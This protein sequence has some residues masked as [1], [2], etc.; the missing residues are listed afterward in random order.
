MS[1]AGTR[2]S[3]PRGMQRSHAKVYDGRRLRDDIVVWE[4]TPETVA[5]NQAWILGQPDPVLQ[6][7]LSDAVA[8][9][10]AFQL[11]IDALPVG[12]DIRARLGSHL[13]AHLKTL[14]AMR[15]G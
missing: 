11:A 13:T 15:H 7:Q 8:S 6:A 9:A 14:E 12:K 2:R 1:T 4:P 5:R 10:N 3:P